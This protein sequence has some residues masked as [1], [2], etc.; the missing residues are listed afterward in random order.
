MVSLLLTAAL[1]AMPV[2]APAKTVSL[3]DVFLVA[4]EA[5]FAA[6]GGRPWLDRSSELGAVTPLFGRFDL[7]ASEVPL[8]G[9]MSVMLM[10]THH[11]QAGW[12]ARVALSAMSLSLQSV[13]CALLALELDE[14]GAEEGAVTS[15]RP[16]RIGFRLLEGNN[17][18]VVTLSGVT[19]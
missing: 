7:V 19:F 13:G 15:V 11:R 4:G 18:G 16:T 8:L 17:G 6:G 9:P 3:G 5:G 2:T 12:Q 1:A 14:P 10:E